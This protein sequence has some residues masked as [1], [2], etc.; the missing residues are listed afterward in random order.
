MAVMYLGRIVEDGPVASLLD[1]PLH[2]YTSAL[3]DAALAPDMSARGRLARLAGEM[4]SA[5]D[6]PSACH[7]HPRCPI[8]VP[9]C[10]IV[11]PTWRSGASG[12]SV[13]CDLVEDSALS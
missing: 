9:R 2:P 10:S 8:A 11:D 12:R 1:A 3:R 7:F 13:R 6:P 5:A 4:P